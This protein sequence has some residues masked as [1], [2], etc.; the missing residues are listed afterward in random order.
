MTKK[1]ILYNCKE[2]RKE[3]KKMKLKESTDAKK[4]FIEAWKAEKN[5]FYMVDDEDTLYI[6]DFPT[7]AEWH[8]VDLKEYKQ[9]GFT[10]DEAYSDMVKD[11][12][13]YLPDARAEKED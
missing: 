8:E 12:E 7:S 9:V 3:E 2:K 4:I 1:E 11:I 6:A 5:P 10:A 13:L